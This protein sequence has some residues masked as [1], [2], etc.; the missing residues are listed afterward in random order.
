MSVKSAQKRQYFVY[1]TQSN[2][3]TALAAF[4]ILKK[5]TLIVH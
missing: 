5:M 3:P 2:I 4:F 1:W